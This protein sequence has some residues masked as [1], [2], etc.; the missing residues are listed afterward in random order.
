MKTY[1]HTIGVSNK[2]FLALL[3]FSFTISC[4]ETEKQ[5]YS[6]IGRYEVIERKQFHYHG[7]KQGDLYNHSYYLLDAKTGDIQKI[8]WI[9]LE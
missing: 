8:D 7:L 6:E 3:I 2:I 9:E 4:A 5:E 1:T